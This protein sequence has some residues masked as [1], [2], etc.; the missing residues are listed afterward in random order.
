LRVAD[1][2]IAATAR[3]TTLPL[4]TAN[5]RPFKAIAGLEVKAFGRMRHKSHLRNLSAA[6]PA[7]RTH[8]S[9]A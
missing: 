3:E 4:A 7:A 1:T 2:L 5:A 9:T 8:R 6:L